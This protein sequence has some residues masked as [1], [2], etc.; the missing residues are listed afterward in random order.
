MGVNMKGSVQEIGDEDLQLQPHPHQEEEEEADKIGDNGAVMVDIPSAFER[1]KNCLV[2][3]E[4]DQIIPL[5]DEELAKPDSTHTAETRLLRG[6]MR[7]LQ[8]LGDGALED[9]TKI[10]AMDGVD[11][12][13]R[14]ATNLVNIKE[15][16][17]KNASVLKC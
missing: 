2:M 5:C 13:V 7:L 12:T 10:I 4:Y 17:K 8:G 6:T 16:R 1:A 3:K 14:I 11:K 15:G 9:F